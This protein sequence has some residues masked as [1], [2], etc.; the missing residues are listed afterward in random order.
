SVTMSGASKTVALLN[1]SNGFDT[2]VVSGTITANSSVWAR[3]LTVTGTLT[4]TG[5]SVVFKTLTVTSGSIV[6]GAVTV[7]GFQVGNSEAG[8]RTTISAFT[9]WT[10][11]TEYKWNHTSSSPTTTITFT[12]GGNVVAQD[13]LAKKNAVFFSNGLVDGSGN[14]VFT[15]LGSDPAMDITTGVLPRYLVLNDGACVPTAIATTAGCWSLTS[16]GAGG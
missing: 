15:M 7:T 12:I 8:A 4:K 9:L 5:Q 3:I 14:I 16:G 2:L 6:D 13:W 1:S 10:I 11:G